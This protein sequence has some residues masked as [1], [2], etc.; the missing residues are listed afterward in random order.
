VGAA[1]G[2]GAVA[3]IKAIEYCQRLFFDGGAHAFSFLGGYYVIVLPVIGG[4]VVG[5]LVHF[6]AP[7]AKGHGVPE[8]MTAIETRGGRM[9]PILILV[10]TVGSAITIGSGGSAGREGPIVQIGA[11]IGSVLGQRFKLDRTRLLTL[12]AAGA[13]GGI[14][15]TF[16]APIAGVMFTFEVLAGEFTITSVGSMVF[17]AVSSSTVV[18]L[19]LGDAPA[20]TVPAWD[21]VSNWELLM[22]LGLGILGAFVALL[23]V[24]ALYGAEDLFDRWSFPAWLKA[25]VAGVAI[26]VIGY[27]FPQVF[28]TGFSAMTEVMSGG[29]GLGLLIAL[30]FARVAA[31]SLTLA[32]GFSG[33]VFAPALFIGSMLGGAY[34]RVMHSLFPSVSAGSGAYA[35]V[36]MAAVF[37]GA[38]RAPVTAIVIVFEMT[39]DY[40][41]MLPLMFATVVST[42]VAARFEPESIYTLKLVRRGIDFVGQRGALPPR[43]VTAMEAM[44]PLERAGHV[45]P[46]MTL[47]EFE[48]YLARTDEHGALVLG[49][50]GELLGLVTEE[51]LEQAILEG[52]SGRTVKDICSPNPLT[53]HQNDTLEEVI[54]RAGMLDLEYIPVVT[55]DRSHKPLGVLSRFDIIRSYAEAISGSD[56]RFVSFQRRRA[57]NVFGLHPVEVDIEAGDTSVGSTLRDVNPPPEAVVISIVRKGAVLVPRGDTVLEEG[58]H[59]AGLALAGATDLLVE[60]LKGKPT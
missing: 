33:G 8:V 39:L 14:A 12:V 5:P 54:K 11:A 3:F 38:A 31:T 47:T 30:V 57:E 56:R 1:T 53:V 43:P 59:V 24:R 2:L 6:L 51:D 18:R 55:S 34:G 32:S 50:S 45:H 4:L 37:A 19:F 28:G 26:G 9:K 36:G 40:K 29:F 60:S 58:D 44:T 42:L 17:A 48:E 25:P 13:A 46:Q 21:Y 52:D 7:E 10:K 20:F 41:V 35:L 15:G 23:F 49:P 22:Y 27:F 16:N